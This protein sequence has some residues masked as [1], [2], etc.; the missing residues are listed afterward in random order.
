METLPLAWTNSPKLSAS[1]RQV[2][3]DYM[4]T[5]ALILASADDGCDGWLGHGSCSISRASQMSVAGQGRHRALSSAQ[6]PA[7]RRQQQS[8]SLMQTGDTC[9]SRDDVQTIRASDL[10]EFSCR[11]FCKYHTQTAEVHAASTDSPAAVLSARMAR[12]SCVS[13]VYY[14]GTVRRAPLWCTLP[15]GL[16]SRRQTREVP[17][18]ILEGHH[19]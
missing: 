6:P 4:P 18:P 3:S 8:C 16:R 10:S 12:W 9:F 13:S 14:N 19:P 1:H 7:D 5:S 17:V 11:P 2:K 15:T